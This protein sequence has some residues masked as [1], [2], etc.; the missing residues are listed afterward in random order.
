MF[1]QDWCFSSFHS[2]YYCV[3]CNIYFQNSMDTCQLSRAELAYTKCEVRYQLTD[4]QIWK[5]DHDWAKS[6]TAQS[7]TRK[8][9]SLFR[10]T[11]EIWNLEKKMIVITR[12]QMQIGSQNVK[13]DLSHFFKLKKW[14]QY[15][16]YLEKNKK[17]FCKWLHPVEEIH[18][19]CPRGW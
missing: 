12:S 10:K 7:R 2:D 11:P 1:I 6:H 3:L 4:Q 15:W 8:W 19:R 18:R 5:V 14:S 16:T 9:H 13:N 17:S